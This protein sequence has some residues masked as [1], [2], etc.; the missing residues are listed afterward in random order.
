MTSSVVAAGLLMLLMMLQLGVQQMLATCCLLN[1]NANRC[2]YICDG[3]RQT[4]KR[5]AE[6]ERLIQNDPITAAADSPRTAENRRMHK[7]S[8]HRLPAK[9]IN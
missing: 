2:C 6:N 4:N 8:P 3:R 9:L 7:V 1:V 5:S